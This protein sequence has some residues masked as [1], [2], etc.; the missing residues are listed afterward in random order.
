[1]GSSLV[2]SNF[3]MGSLSFYGS[4]IPDDAGIVSVYGGRGGGVT[5]E[6]IPRIA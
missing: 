4:I 2:F 3:V 5:E 6:L 1:M